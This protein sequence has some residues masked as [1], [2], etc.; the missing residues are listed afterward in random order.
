M[1]FFCFHFFAY[2]RG[3]SKNVE[4][5][6]R[7]TLPG[8]PPTLPQKMYEARKQKT[9][10]ARR[11]IGDDVYTEILR[12]RPSEYLANPIAKGGE[13]V[14]FE[15]PDKALSDAMRSVV[16]KVNFNETVPHLSDALSR[17]PKKL[18]RVRRDMEEKIAERRER[19]KQLRSYFGFD[20]VPAEQTMVRDIPVSPAIIKAFAPHVETTDSF[21]DK[22]PAWLTVQRRLDL[23]RGARQH[24]VSL[25]G[26]YPEASKKLTGE[27]PEE[28]ARLYDEAH[29]LLVGRSEEA[30]PDIRREL[31]CDMYPQ[32]KPV[33]V[34]A[35]R[36]L[37]FATKL[38]DVAERLVEY[39]K[40]TGVALDLVGN[41]NVLLLKDGDEW[42]LKM[43]DALPL[44]DARFSDVKMAYDNLLQR[45]ESGENV[46]LTPEET[47][48]VF[49]PLNTIRVVNAL[50]MLSGSRKRMSLKGLKQIPPSVWREGIQEYIFPPKQAAA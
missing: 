27:D 36:D 46:E 3:M 22:I 29:D 23:P 49:N 24:H 8:A 4:S 38:R 11:L 44:Y 15:V 33:A 25:N 26:S 20:A 45:A 16:V 13:H 43:P 47:G 7:D 9:E 6:R 30:D 12:V 34:L 41:D 50:A 48:H 39:S 21:P 18:E 10:L 32:L 5:G 42:K 14:V 35:E 37:S 17:D 2:H 28:A 40:E 19:L 31:I 1:E